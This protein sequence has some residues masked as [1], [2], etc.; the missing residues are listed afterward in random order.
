MGLLWFVLGVVLGGGGMFVFYKKAKSLAD[1]A[2]AEATELK[3][4]LEQKYEDLKK[5]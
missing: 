3:D 2:L 1:K 4:E 5:K